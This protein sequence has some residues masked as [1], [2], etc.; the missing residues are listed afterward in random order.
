VISRRDGWRPGHV[1]REPARFRRGTSRLL[2]FV[3]WPLVILAAA[4]ALLRAID[5]S[6]HAYLALALGLLPVTMLPAYPVAVAAALTRRRGLATLAAVLAATHLYFVWPAIQPADDVSSVARGAATVRLLSF[7]TGGGAAAPEALQRLIR[8][9]SPDVLILL[10]LDPGT[11]ATLDRGGLAETYP[12]RLV[13]PSEDALGGAGLYSRFPLEDAAVLPTVTG[14]MPGATVRVGGSAV[15]IQSVHIAPPLGNLVG[16]WQAEHLALATLARER[17]QSL[18]LAG[19]FNSGRQ[20]R[21][22]REVVDAGLTDAHEARARGYVRT[23]P[24]DRAFLPPVLDLDHVL[25]SEGVVVLEV[26]ERGGLG[27]D[28]RALLTDIAVVS[29]DVTAGR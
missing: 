4:T 25:V 20:H 18:V 21:E 13:K 29:P 7:N 2:P 12:H 27:S 5:A 14:T 23:W 19:D 24:D 17:R 3:A 1:R 11:A 15:R 22:W 9:D 8:R 6:G 16:R 26:R 10:E 28:H